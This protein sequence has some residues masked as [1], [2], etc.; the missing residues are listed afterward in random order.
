MPRLADLIEN[1]DFLAASNQ[2]KRLVF[3]R[4]SQQDETF[5]NASPEAQRIVRRKLLGEE[6]PR[7]SP[8]T[9]APVHDPARQMP[10]VESETLQAPSAFLDPIEFVTGAGTA[11]VTGALAKQGVK[12][13]GKEALRQGLGFQ[14]LGISE[15]PAIVKHLPGFIKNFRSALGPITR[16][17][18]PVSPDLKAVQE[19]AEVARNRALVEMRPATPTIVEKQAV[20]TGLPPGTK[21]KVPIQNAPPY[22]HPELQAAKDR[23]AARA[24]AK[25]RLPVQKAPPPPL[26]FADIPKAVRAEGPLV[27]TSVTVTPVAPVASTNS[28][29]YFGFGKKV[30]PT[31]APVEATFDNHVLPTQPALQTY[32]SRLAPMLRKT[33]EL[34]P[35]TSAIGRKI[36]DSPVMS[37]L[38]RGS[39]G[40]TEEFAALI[41]SPEVD[42]A[43]ALGDEAFH[44]AEYDAYNLFEQAGGTP[45]ATERSLRQAP[46]GF[47]GLARM[48]QR[49]F[50]EDQANRAILGLEALPERAGPYV[51]RLT[52]QDSEN[53]VKLGIQGTN[54]GEAY[55]Q[56]IGSFANSRIHRTALEGMAQGVTYESPLK[57]ALIRR[58]FSI[59]LKHTAN[60]MR[61]LQEGGVIFKDKAKALAASPTRQVMGVQGLPGS[62]ELW[63]ARSREEGRYI[64]DHFKPGKGG[65]LQG[66]VSL[67]NQFFRNPN[68]V[69]PIPHFAKNMLFK[70]RLSGGSL[71]RVAQDMRAFST[72]SHP[73]YETF[74]QL[75][76]FSESG[77]T[78]R[79]LMA[80]EFETGPISKAVRAL[81]SINKFSSREIFGYLDPALKFSR[82]VQYVEKDGLTPQAAANRVMTN[83]IEYDSRSAAIDFWKSIPGNFF[84]NW[85]VGTYASLI[86]S[87]RRR[88]LQ[89]TAFIGAVDYI[90]EIDYRK[91][92]R[93]FHLPIDYVEGPVT[94]LIKDPRNVKSVAASLVMLG[95][96]GN[97][98]T[99]KDAIAAFDNKSEDYG[100]IANMFWG[101]SQ[102]YNSVDEFRQFGQDGD[103]ATHFANF[104]GTMALSEH[105]TRGIRPNTLAQYLP[106]SLPG[107][108]YDLMVRQKQQE[109]EAKRERAA[110]AAETREK[111]RGFFRPP[112]MRQ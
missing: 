69:N 99:L 82:F 9:P 110:K 112:A 16:T 73:L 96:G 47:A 104:I 41:K 59:R 64:V 66:V 51:G 27:G 50:P 14:T 98:K 2:A 55:R 32:W 90:R 65:S 23:A 19:A 81:G 108:T 39:N 34:F 67:M 74:R 84:V 92:G 100:R 80:K 106:E 13:I 105:N 21:V 77:E 97:L 17:T 46:Q 107:L 68:L 44:R 24:A 62:Q 57:S 71:S 3:D 28:R 85:R 102:L 56:S 49:S 52:V 5:V 78:A 36:P 61:E 109:Y 25:G 42:A 86:D 12:Q 83:L 35:S 18:P 31:T 101:L 88:S 11:G 22:V 70:Y 7:P 60:I 89:A 37:I 8:I 79:Q 43:R 75:I 53:L 48:F 45:D 40:M 33:I 95:P 72:K 29:R 87:L 15:I 91:R 58:W 103:L 63:W 26:I 1:Q 10:T 93:S 54:F 20:P 4:V 6:S 30:D 111:A 76:P 38:K 94:S